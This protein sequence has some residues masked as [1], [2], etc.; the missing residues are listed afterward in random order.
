MS[1]FERENRY[2]VLKRRDVE[3]CGKL[4]T[5]E[6]WSAFETIEKMVNQIRLNSGKQPLLALVVESD[7]PEYEQTWDAIKRRM[8]GGTSIMEYMESERLDLVHDAAHLANALTDINNIWGE[9][10]EIKAVIKKM[11]SKID[12]YKGLESTSS[13]D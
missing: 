6:A 2:I 4:L 11:E 7:W 10:P 8:E 1:E 13:H 9:H 3:A 12:Q 5:P